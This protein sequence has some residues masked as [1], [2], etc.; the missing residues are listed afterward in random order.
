MVPPA[1]PYS[2]HSSA[3]RHGPRY[4]LPGKKI[5]SKSGETDPRRKITRHQDL[6]RLLP[7]GAGSPTLPRTTNVIRLRNLWSRIKK[8]NNFSLGP[9]PALPLSGAGSPTLPRPVFTTNLIRLLVLW[10]RIKNILKAA[11]YSGMIRLH[12]QMEPDH[13][14]SRGGL[15]DQLIRL[16]VLWSRIKINKSSS[17]SG[18]IRLHAQ[19][20]RITNIPQL[21]NNPVPSPLEPD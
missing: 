18:M 6:I 11:S 16:R 19:W 21:P 1:P 2:T 12:S 17:C 4:S 10:S 3:K 5:R 14:H 13:Q 7:T 20:S 15:H 8:T 9:D